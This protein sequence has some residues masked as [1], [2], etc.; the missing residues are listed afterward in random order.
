MVDRTM[1]YPAGLTYVVE[2]PCVQASS[3]AVV[4]SILSDCNVEVR[5]PSLVLANRNRPAVAAAEG[6]AD[7]VER[8][9]D[10]AE[11]LCSVDV[12]ETGRGRC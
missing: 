7:E 5:W 4:A 1:S 12:R 2:G 10:V 11:L 9:E 8:V 6:T 3:G